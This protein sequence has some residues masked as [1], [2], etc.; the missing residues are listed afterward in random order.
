MLQ[1]ERTRMTYAKVWRVVWT[2]VTWQQC[3]GLPESRRSPSRKQAGG[4]VEG[5]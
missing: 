3:L 2:S 4:H 1:A 5:L